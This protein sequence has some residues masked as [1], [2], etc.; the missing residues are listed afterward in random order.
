MAHAELQID[1]HHVTRVEGHGN[2][3]ID[4]HDGVLEQCN[5]EIVEAPRFFEAMLRGQPYTQASLISSRICGICAVTHATAS[6]R[7]VESALAITPSRQ[8]VL[9]RKLALMGE[10][11]DSHILHIYM[12]ALPDLLGANSVIQLAKDAPDPRA[13]QGEELGEVIEIPEVGCLNHHYERRAA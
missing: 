1:I 5:L 9:L 11:L 13:I 8:T 4:V 12:L 6:L 2:I 10:M 3:V 7:A